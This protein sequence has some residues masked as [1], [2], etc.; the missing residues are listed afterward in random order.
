VNPFTKQ[1]LSVGYK[2]ILEARKK[3]PVFAQMKEFYEMVSTPYFNRH[4]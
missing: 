4:V 3:L 2:K 1:P